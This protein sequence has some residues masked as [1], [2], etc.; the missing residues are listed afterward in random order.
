MDGHGIRI[1]IRLNTYF[2]ALGTMWALEQKY[3]K[4]L[5]LDITSVGTVRFVSTAL[6]LSKVFSNDFILFL[7]NANMFN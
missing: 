1:R 3:S 2:K 4:L 5:S 6:Q 7:G